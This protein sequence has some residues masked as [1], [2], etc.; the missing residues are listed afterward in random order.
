[1]RQCDKISS[2]TYRGGGQLKGPVSEIIGAG[3]QLFISRRNQSEELKLLHVNHQVSGGGAVH[4]SARLFMQSKGR[5]GGRSKE[6]GVG[7]GVREMEKLPMSL[8]PTTPSWLR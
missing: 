3:L 1:M 7:V 2:G 4:L 5:G 6:V 8:Q